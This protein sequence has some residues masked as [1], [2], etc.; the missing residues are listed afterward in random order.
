MCFLATIAYND[1]SVGQRAVL[2]CSFGSSVKR[3]E[4]CSRSETSNN[5]E[6][7]MLT[8]STASVDTANRSHG[9]RHSHSSSIIQEWKPYYRE[10]WKGKRARGGQRYRW[11]DDITRFSLGFMKW[12]K[13]GQNKLQDLFL[14]SFRGDIAQ[15]TWTEYQDWNALLYT[16]TYDACIKR[17]NEWRL[18]GNQPTAYLCKRFTEKKAV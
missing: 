4:S 1:N 3:K 7:Q 8:G 6:G 18:Q 10:K 9:T 2:A 14:P 17:R 12:A 13:S 5:I 16:Y 15:D 11:V